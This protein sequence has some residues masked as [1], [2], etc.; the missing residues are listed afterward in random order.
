LTFPLKT[1]RWWALDLKE[2]SYT[3]YNIAEFI[4]SD[5]AIAII[6]TG[7]SLCAIPA[8][9]HTKMEKIWTSEIGS[10]LFGCSK[11]IC[12][13]GTDCKSTAKKM[14]PISIV[15]DLHQFDI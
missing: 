15:I 13:S 4:P 11:G 1:N 6:D 2:F 9:I 3:G 5:N 12:I 7:T 8:K 14:S 10:D